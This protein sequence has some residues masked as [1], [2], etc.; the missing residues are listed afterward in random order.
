MT[1]PAS[2]WN[3]VALGKL[4]KVLGERA[5]RELM[6]EG[7]LELGVDELRSAG[8]L[9]RFANRLAAKGGFAAAVGGLL[10]LHATMYEPS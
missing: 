9:R 7:L 6:K 8:D 4:T 1:I 5:G 10:N 2:D 3:S